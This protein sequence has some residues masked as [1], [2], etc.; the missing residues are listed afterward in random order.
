MA[1]DAALRLDV[2][3]GIARIS[4]DQPGARAN[5]LGQPILGEFEAIL[6]QLAGR[7]D[8]RGMILESGKPGMF[9]A[10]ADLKEL[11]AATPEHPDLTRKLIQ[12][13]LN[14]IASFEALPFPTIALIDGPCMGGGTEIALGCDMRL[15]GTHPKCEIG[16]PEVKVGL[17]PGWGGT[18]RLTRLIGPSQAVEMICSGEAVKA[19]RTKELGIVFDVVASDKLRQEGV[20]LLTEMHEFGSWKDERRRKQLPVGLSEEQVQFTFGVARAMI[21]EKTKGQ[22]PAPLAAL[23]AIEKGCN[24]TLEE[25]LKIETEAM[26]P[27]LGS[28]ISKN[29][30]GVFFMTQKLAKDSGVADA[31]VQPKAIKR[32]GILGAGIM[33]AGIA[34]AHVR[35]GLPVVLLDSVPQ[36]LEKG[37]AG[38]AAGLKGLAERGRMKP[39]ELVAALARLGTAASL[40]NVAECDVVIEAIVENE[41]AKTTLFKQLEPMLRPEA[42]L[43]SNTSTIS[44]SRMAKVLAK[45]ERFAGM[46]FFNPAEKMPLV[47]VIRGEK[48]SDATIVTLVALAK[49]VGKTPIVVKDAPGFLVNRILFPYMDEAALLLVEGADPRAIDKAATAF[50]M[51]MGPITLYDVVGLDTSLYAGRVMHAAFPDRAVASPLLEE[52]VAK[53]RLGQKSGAGFYKYGK[54]LKGSD[55]P[56]FAE[57][58]AKYRKQPRQFSQEEITERLFLPMLTEATRVLEEGIVRDPADVDMGLILGIG[59]P[60]WRGGLLRWADSLGVP[61]VL[62]LLKKHESL[63][64][65]FAPT[66]SLRHLAA[67]GGRLSR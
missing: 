35:K 44:I 59:F 43:A 25:G 19:A 13:G 53:G 60:A 26:I 4:F 65:R 23:S 48:T 49:Q 47:E 7:S 16:L 15:A 39:E 10:G 3:D 12:R 54:G 42:I 14:V 9:I 27:L 22:L 61:K 28:P 56:A 51:P 63:G 45:P 17:I 66:A 58:L 32:V 6:K 2:T 55:D 67:A 57:I 1:T 5:T 62:E 36:A 18:Q 40:S 11:G 21:M 64:T 8:I 38:I 20:R 33:G 52:L 31:N 30:I 46:H 29:L 41:Q 50:G 34:A 24:R 37:V